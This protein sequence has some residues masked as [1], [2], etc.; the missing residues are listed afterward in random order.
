M[1]DLQRRAE[2]AI[3]RT[4]LARPLVEG[5][6]RAESQ[7]ALGDASLAQ[8]AP[9]D[10]MTEAASRRRLGETVAALR[11]YVAALEAGADASEVRRRIARLPLG[12]LPLQQALAA[13]GE[14][15]RDRYL[16]AAGLSAWAAETPT[17][18]AGGGER[19]LLRALRSLEAGRFAEA[20]SA[21][22]AAQQEGCSPTVARETAGR[23]HERQAEQHLERGHNSLAVDSYGQALLAYAD[24]AVV[25]ALEGGGEQGQGVPSAHSQVRETLGQ[26]LLG[27]GRQAADL[28]L[29]MRARSAEGEGPAQALETAVEELGAAVILLDDPAEV[30]DMLGDLLWESGRKEEARQHYKAALEADR[31]TAARGVS[32]AVVD[33]LR[34]FIEKVGR[35][36]IGIVGAIFLLVTATSLLNTVE[37]TLNAIWQV[38]EPRPLWIRFTSYWTLIALGPVLIIAGIWAQERL[39]HQIAATMGGVPFLRYVVGVASAAGQVLL[40]FLTVWLALIGLYKFLPHTRVRFRCVARGAFVATVLVQL[41]RPLFSIYVAKVVTYEK[42]YGSLGAVPIFLLWIWLLWLIVLFGA[43]VSFTIQNVGLLRYHDKLRRL[44]SVFID[45]YL[46]V[47]LMMYVAREFWES[48][49]PVTAVRL[50]DILQISTEEAADACR[51][52]VRLGLLTPVGEERDMFHPARDLSKLKLT[53]VLSI[54]DRFRDESRSSH[55]ADCPYEEKLEG[56]FRAAIAAQDE[57]LENMTFRDL[58]LACERT[59]GVRTEG[60]ASANQHPR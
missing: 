6:P 46:A 4:V 16:A 27:R 42:V 58:L 14:E 53:E 45:R 52:L 5:I 54:S 56:V 24:A 18:G 30:G 19:E 32:M 38:S 10:L 23:V 55:V 51:R 20:L 17:A 35:A 36:G 59:G 21:L 28:Y 43:E 48:G 47:R 33:Y 34:L 37:T 44:S 8:M 40:P 3:F 60:E 49:Q 26:L 22:Q 2:D 13:A 11:M 15:A 29:S 41:A 25:A 31:A 39:G 57:A 50:A 1:E 9:G 7:T 12:S